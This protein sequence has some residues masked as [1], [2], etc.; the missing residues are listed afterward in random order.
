VFVCMV[1]PWANNQLGRGRSG[2]ADRRSRVLQLALR[3]TKFKIFTGGS[4]V[5]A[6]NKISEGVDQFFEQNWVNSRE[7]PR[8]FSH[9]TKNWRGRPLSTHEVVV[10]LI[11][12]NLIANTTTAAELT[13][14]PKIRRNYSA[15]LGFC[16]LA[17][18][19]K[20]RI[21]SIWVI[22]EDSS[23]TATQLEGKRRG[24]AE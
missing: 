16:S 9:I 22:C 15:P 5:R 13:V 20:R 2:E 17:R 7:R 19:E 3:Y 10:N 14:K 18:S 12:N 6:E 11:A 23:I 24:G 4:I 21:R 1:V 8:L